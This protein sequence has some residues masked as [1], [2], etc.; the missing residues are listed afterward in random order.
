MCAPICIKQIPSGC[1]IE[2]A[3]LRQRR[4]R[5][6]DGHF[7]HRDARCGAAA[8]G[9]YR[10][11]YAPR[12]TLPGLQTV[13]VEV[14]IYCSYPNMFS[15]HTRIGARAIWQIAN[16]AL[17]RLWLPRHRAQTPLE[18]ACL[19]HIETAALLIAVAL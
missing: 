5:I 7:A 6:I 3:Q 19:V 14:V 13:Y 1:S 12:T 9:R 18:R 8:N 15:L 11:N 4:R 16:A 2:C 17:A 10:R